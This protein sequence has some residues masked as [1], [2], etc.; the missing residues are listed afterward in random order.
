MR[1]DAKSAYNAGRRNLY[2]Q[3]ARKLDE[4]ATELGITR[5]SAM[6]LLI[7]FYGDALKETLKKSG[8]DELKKI[9]RNGATIK[10]QEA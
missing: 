7:Q 1:K 9:A 6:D 3:N 10:V 5:N 8:E 2:L 4:L